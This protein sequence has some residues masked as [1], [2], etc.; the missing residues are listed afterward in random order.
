VGRTEDVEQRQNVVEAVDAS[1]V[2]D[3][4]QL[5]GGCLG[6]GSGELDAAGGTGKKGLDGSQLRQ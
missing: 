1:A 2:T 3:R 5:R 6:C 4:Q